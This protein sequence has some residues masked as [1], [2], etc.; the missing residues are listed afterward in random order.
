[1][2]TTIDL[3]DPLFR[4][5]KALSSLRGQSLKTFVTGA[6]RHELESSSLR[7]ETRRVQFPIVRSK[8]PG[9]INV[10]ADRIARI[11]EKE[12]NALSS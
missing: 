3:P 2:R 11:L 5:A 4:K 8:R 10:T 9:S 12:D 7:L 6:I 1:M